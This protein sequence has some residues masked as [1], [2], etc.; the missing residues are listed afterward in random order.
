MSAIERIKN[1]PVI[2]LDAV[3]YALAMAVAF[4]APLADSQV[5]AVL[6]FAGAFLALALTLFTRQQVRPEV[7][8]QQDMA[9]AYRDGV[10]DAEGRPRPRPDDAATGSSRAPRLF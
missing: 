10:A 8:A 9:E 2:V 5:E 1:E 4:G 3:K 6:A 7:K